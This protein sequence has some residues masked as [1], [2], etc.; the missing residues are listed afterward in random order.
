MLVSYVL[1]SPLYATA[2]PYT[3]PTG[4]SFWLPPESSSVAP[5]VDTAF[6]FVLY[7]SA[8]FFILIVTLMT[9]FVLRYRR[10]PGVGP[11][12]SPSHSTLLEVTWSVI[13][14]ILVAIMF[15]LGFAGFIDMR[16]PPRD[17]YD[18]R[19]TGQKWS[20]NFQYPGG[21]EDGNLHVPVDEPVRLTMSSKDVIH[22]LYVPAFR[23]KQDL[24]PG[25]YTT[26]WFRATQPGEYD[27]ECAEYCGTSHSDMLAKVIV[28][29]PG[30]FETWL[31]EAEKQNK[32]LSPVDRGR[33]LY[34]RR[35]CAACHSTDG[36]AKTGPSFKGIY[37]E[38]HDFEN[39]PPT[40]V[41]DNYIR[42]SILTPSAKIR[43]GFPDK[44]TVYKG[45]LSDDQITALIEFI[46]SL[47]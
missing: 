22:S 18:I 20:W 40:K 8:F 21:Y 3:G 38:T 15:G 39:A 26:A 11:G 23:I 36:T 29:R 41:D 43:K 34:L 14:L 27:L 7:V 19:V 16:T 32:N 10:R 13:P 28:H 37:G 30:E 44:M 33:Q 31:Q 35:G 17:A 2:G 46:K 4:G 47:K 12:Q 42:E 25:R 5:L 24:V 9:F 1:P 6:Y 45:Q